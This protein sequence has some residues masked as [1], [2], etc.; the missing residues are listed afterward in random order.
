MSRNIFRQFDNSLGKPNIYF[1][2]LFTGLTILVTA[3][4]KNKLP[5]KLVKPHFTGR[6]LSN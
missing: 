4:K 6:V 5:F 3:F 1:N 2:S